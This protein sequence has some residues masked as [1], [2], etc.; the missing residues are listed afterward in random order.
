MTNHTNYLKGS[1][2]RK[3][4]LHIHTP[5]TKLSNNYR[6]DSDNN[7]VWGQFCEIIANS[8]VEVFGITDYFS[9]NNYFVFCDIF[10][11]KYPDSK[12]TFFPNV[13]LRLE[14]SV[15]RD[16]QEVNIHVIF[17]DKV[18]KSKMEEFLSKLNTNITRNGA[19][20]S[21]KNLEENDFESAGIDYK[22]I[23]EVL[24][25][26]FGKDK[27]Y[28]IFAAANN[29]GLRPDNTSPRKL[30]ISDEIDK[31]CDGFFGGK[32]NTD[33]WLDADRYESDEIAIPKP[34][35]SGCDSH[36]F[37]DLI[38]WLG[39]RVIR[40]G[41]EIHKDVTWIKADTTFEGLK[42]IIYEPA[43]RI[44]IQEN[45]PAAPVRQISQVQLKFNKETKIKLIKKDVE[46]KFCFAG[47]DTTLYLSDFFSCFIGGR[48][49]GKSTL[50]NLIFKAFNPSAKTV[51]FSDNKITV[52]GNNIDIGECVKLENTAKSVEFLEQ[53][54]IEKF[55]TD[56]IEFTKAIYIRLKG[57]ESD[58]EGLEGSL[59]N[60]LTAIDDQIKRL[61]K[62]GKLKQ[63]IEQS[64]KDYKAAKKITDIVETS[65]YKGI[66]GTIQEINKNYLLLK[67]DREKLELLSE[68]IQAF[69]DNHHK[70]DLREESSKYKKSYNEFL[71]ELGKLSS[72]FFSSENFESEMENENNLLKKIQTNQKELEE[73]L[74]KQGLSEE[75]LQDVKIAGI[76]ADEHKIF[77]EEKEK[78]L[79]ILEKQISNYQISNIEVVQEQYDT[80]V[81]DTIKD[82]MQVLD[83]VN[84][85]NPD[86][87]KIYLQF[88]F[89]EEVAKEK[90]FEEFMKMFEDYCQGLKYSESHLKSCL[91]GTS[92]FE[93]LR[94]KIGYDEVRKAVSGNNNYNT[95]LENIFEN[96]LNYEIYK[97]QV[98][99]H[100]YNSA[101]Y[102]KIDVSYRDK[103][104]EQASFGQKC[105][106]VIVIM[107]L[108]G[109]NP[110]I[111]DEP[112][113]HL[114]SSLI[115]NYLVNLIKKEKLKRQVIFATHNANFVIN[116]DAEQIYILE[117]PEKQTM[118]I[119]TTIEDLDQRE[120]LLKLEGGEKA[121]SK[122]E[123]KYGFR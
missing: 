60:S 61:E 47:V 99:K 38:K 106:A 105:T 117:M 64:D 76:R 114:D 84:K 66:T 9:I 112:E 28:L 118:F 122:R 41:N 54:Q 95:I 80:K 8:D 4:D 12:K 83:E 49:T 43:D 21:C 18:E 77:K 37:D 42:Q 55:A 70:F 51:F 58:I 16:A 22:K 20:I 39:K 87:D 120:K 111:I 3:W 53:N 97:L 67:N 116:A 74:E 10:T 17:S 59:L 89:N 44:K 107:L 121:F 108:F 103:P 6:A 13:E 94:S 73:Y 90:L 69:L 23:K 110:I 71:E 57:R 88:D 35:I 72:R 104:I 52:D 81:K 45:K 119:Q 100:F 62:K 34:V 31:I 1:E 50:L 19:S 30:S 7:D 15:N 27:C 98:Q 14:V 115:A 102:L 78:E 46:A 65:E 82:L 79:D 123:M 113:A 92:P 48:G 33:Y 96:E 63:A 32:Q 29:A 68:E 86:V 85:G 75:N 2:W 93:I 56:Q 25:E 101:N 109:H 40:N 24:K 5:E 11:T 26:V 91:F 36:S